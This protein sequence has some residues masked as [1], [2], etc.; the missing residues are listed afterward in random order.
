MARN[1]YSE[2]LAKKTKE[3]KSSKQKESQQKSTSVRNPYTDWL[4]RKQSE[5]KSQEI[6]VKEYDEPFTAQ[7]DAYLANRNAQQIK[8]NAAQAR[9]NQKIYDDGYSAP[10]ESFNRLKEDR[11]KRMSDRIGKKIEAKRES[12]SSKSGFTTSSGD[13]VPYN[14]RILNSQPDFEEMVKQ[15]KEKENLFSGDVTYGPLDYF[16]KDRREIMRA[17]NTNFTYMTEQEKELYYYLNGKYGASEAADYVESINKELNARSAGKVAEET[18]KL[19]QANPA[20]GLAADAAFHIVGSGAYPRM[21]AGQAYNALTGRYKEID[22][23]DPRY[24]GTTIMNE[25]LQEGINENETLKKIIPNEGARNFA[26]GTA[27]SIAENI[28]RLPFGSL[29]LGMAAASAGASGTRDVLQRGGTAGQA[30]SLGVLNAA[31]EAFFEKFSLENLQALKTSPGKGVKT[32]LRNLGK[33]AVVE[34]SEE[35]ATEIANTMTDQAIMG[36][37]STYQVAYQNYIQQGMTEE[38]AKKQAFIDFLGNVGL[39]GLGGAVSGGLMGGAG[40]AIG[41]IQE[42]YALDQYGS[43]IDQDYR[44]YASSLDPNRENYAAEA[45]YQE[46]MSLRSLAEE[47]ADRQGRGEFIRNRDK[48]EYDIRLNRLRESMAANAGEAQQVGQEAEEGP[49]WRPEEAQERPYEA[50]AQRNTLTQENA[51]ETAQDEPDAVRMWSREF[52]SNGQK[53]FESN[54][55]GETDLPTYYRAFG[56]VYNAGRYGFDLTADQRAEA[57]VVLSQEAF[58][59]ALKAGYQDL[60]ANRGYDVATGRPFGAVQGQPKNGGI[61]SVSVSATQAQRKVASHVGKLTGL[62]IDLVDSL[63]TEGATGSYQPGR[64]TIDINSQ[65]FNASMAHELTHFIKEQAPSGYEVFEKHVVK[66]MTNATGMDLESSLQHVINRYRD[67]GKNLNRAQAMEELVADSTQ[68]FMN[69]PEFI[70]QVIKDDRSLGQKIIDFFTDV[71]DALKELIQTGSTRASARALEEQVEIYERARDNWYAILE[72]AS[73]NYKSG[74]EV[75]G[76]EKNRIEHPDQVADERIEQNFETVRKMEPVVNLK[77][78]EFGKG[79]RSLKDRVIEFYE[80]I[81]KVHNETVGDIYLTKDSVKDDLAHGVGRVKAITFAAVPDILQKGK[82]LKYSK[83]WK[84]RGYDSVI[85]GAP[86]HIAEG[87]NAGDYYGLAVV[88]VMEDN[89]MYLHEVF[90]AKMGDVTPIKTPDFQGSNTRSDAYDLPSIYSIFGKLL[91]VNEG[92]ADNVKFQ[93]KE[94]V[95]ETKDLIAVH[96]L[97][98]DKLMKMLQYEGIPMPSI[99]VTKAD[100]GHEDFGDISLIFRKD[101]IDPKNRKNKVYGADAWT[102][103]FPTIEYELDDNRA[104]LISAKID[105]LVQGKVPSRYSQM[106]QSFVRNLKSNINSYGGEDGLIEQA[107]ENT[108][109]QAVYLASQGET[110]QEKTK[111]IRTE[112]LQEDR[113]LAQAIVNEFGDILTE[114]EGWS[115]RRIFDS[116]GGRIKKAWADQLVQKGETREAAEDFVNKKKGFVIASKF[117]AAQKYIKTGGVEVHTET[118]Y[119][120]MEKEIRSK[121]NGKDYR[122]W[123]KNLFSGIVRDSGVS[124]NKEPFYADGRRKNF[125]QT[126][127]PVTAAN[128]VK[129]MLSQSDDAR[130]VSSFHGIKSI[131]AVATE[132]FKSIDQIKK[133]SGRI[134]QLD[135]EQY[136]SLEDNLGTRLTQTIS[137]I[138]EASGNSSNRF[139]QMDSVGECIL[140]ACSNPTQANIKK[141]LEKYEWKVTEAQAG[142]LAQ[143]IKEVQE[144]P[145]DMFEAKPQRVVGYDEIAA[146]VVPDTAEDEVVAALEQKGIPVLLYGD[147]KEGDRKKKI[148]SLEGI[149]FQLEEVEDEG[150]LIRNLQKENKHL[151][152]A[153]ESLK[154]QFKL[155]KGDTLRQDDIKKVA[156]N[157]LKDYGSKY[158]RETLER[159]LTKLYDYIRSADNVDP[160]VVNEL[161]NGIAKS[162]LNNA[163]QIDQE[164]SEQYKDL[165]KQ[166]RNTKVKIEAQDKADLAAA[167]G[168]TEFRKKYFGKLR[169]GNDGISIDS[170]YQELNSQYP[171]LFPAEFTH[172]ADQLMAVANAVDQIQERVVNP[173][174]ANMDEM[175]V[176]LGSEIKEAYYTVRNTPPTFA[177]RKTAEL[178]GARMAYKRSMDKYKAFLRKQYESGAKNA[179]QAIIDEREKIKTARN[180]LLDRIE[181]GGMNPE[182][183]KD[184]K[185]EE[186]ELRERLTDLNRQLAQVKYIAQPDEYVENMRQIRERRQRS[187]DKETVLRDVKSMQT[188]L[189]QPNKQKHVPD[190]LKGIVLE[191]LRSID[192]STDYLN[193]NGEK[194]ARTEAWDDL[195][196]FWNA[197]KD[198]NEWNGQYYDGDPDIA[199]R[200]TDLKGKVK[201][202]EKLDDLS[203]ADMSSLRRVVSSMKKTIMEVN[204]LKANQKAQEVEA[205]GGAVI[206][207]LDDISQ[208]RWKTQEGKDEAI[209][210][211]SEFVGPLGTADKLLNYD[212][213]TPYTV[214]WKMG[215]NMLS[216]YQSFRKAADRKTTQLKEADDYVKKAVEDLGLTRKEINE[217]TG[218]NAKA[219]TFKTSGGEISLTPAMVMSLYVTNKRG[220]GRKH[221][222]GDG[223]KNAPILSKQQK[224]GKGGWLPSKVKRAYRPVR[225]TPGDV[226]AITNSLSQKQKDFA[227]RMQQFLMLNAADWGNEASLLMYGYKKFMS[228]DYWPILTDQNYIYS[229]EGDLSNLFLT[230][231]NFGMTKPVT[232]FANNAVIIDDIFDV[233]SRHVDQMSTYSAFL[234][235]LS[236]FNKVYNYKNSENLVSVKQEIERAMGTKGKDYLERLIRDIN[237][238]E[239]RDSTFLDSM[240]SNAKGAAVAGSLSVAIQQPSAYLRAAA[241]INP[242]YLAEG[243]FTAPTKQLWNRICKYAPIAQW[244]DWGFYQMNTSRPLKDIL[245]DTDSLKNRINNVAMMGA[246]KADQMTWSW[247]WKACENEIKDTHKELEPGTEAF[248]RQVGDRFSEIIDKTQ[249]VDSVLHRTQIMRSKD[250][251]VKAATAFMGEPLSTYNMLYRA[252]VD[253][254]RRNKGAKARAAGVAAAFVATNALGAALKSIISALRDDD[255]DKNY[256]QKYVAAFWGLDG[257]FADNINPFAMIPLGKDVVS[258]IKGYEPSRMEMQGFS[259]LW[260]MIQRV[261]KL[262]IGESK[263][264]A[265]K[266][267]ADVAGAVG[268]LFGLPVQ[269]VMK[270]A[271]ALITTAIQSTSNLKDDYTR[272]KSRYDIANEDNRSRY[273]QYIVQA[274]K[275]G[276]MELASQIY[277]DLEE[278]GQDP[279]KIDSS[280]NS[281]L[282]K[283]YKEDELVMAAAEAKADND[284]KGYGEA[285]ESL[286]EAGYNAKRLKSAINSLETEIYKERGEENPRDRKEEPAEEEEDDAEEQVSA[287][288]SKDLIW[289][290]EQANDNVPGAKE[291]YNAIVTE[292]YKTKIANGME[293]KK[294]IQSLRTTISNAFKPRW[295]AA[296]GKEKD[297]IL[298]MV[299]SL[300]V[301][302]RYIFS[303]YDFNNWKKKKE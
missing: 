180:A 262:K 57:A 150:Q 220:Q 74:Q 288:E 170:F 146:A 104:N 84:N 145:V 247:I 139:M 131:R 55:D 239:R 60:N 44:E 120:G 185:R 32:F 128:I 224:D 75:A 21:L 12:E 248:Y 214:F 190:E 175:A 80:Q 148:N 113:E 208:E 5:Q 142:E 250:F 28:A 161:A 300:K 49:E 209:K 149:K 227:D 191:F 66:A 302:D 261:N 202:I 76:E 115:G 229:A 47:Y 25:G 278:S 256:W 24:F 106:A 144:M 187:R 223:I 246:Q 1:P 68:R 210:G 67:A 86:I 193:R 242:K 231:R 169:L 272:A 147:G 225:V 34:G 27:T 154:K 36:E 89:R 137:D 238:G 38:Q 17:A 237:G 22:P 98:A 273:A 3:E 16:N 192:Y 77:G 182:E 30:L 42:N 88:K 240:L 126:H 15:G 116:Y 198:G 296:E 301:N 59:A 188:W 195:Q 79:E 111:E 158:K 295:Q 204:E 48:A 9:K 52:E 263:E 221:I 118:D 123:L 260:A 290:I 289:A 172:P 258:I 94:P 177:D 276:N 194:T 286:I 2:W 201:G 18:K 135:T 232:R 61:G 33:Q 277:S 287:Y 90:T 125:K 46:A 51:Q 243:V 63:E 253:V 107:M 122:S 179:K 230:V 174:H 292:I 78:D 141:T 197:V 73:E 103:T 269:N 26:T 234:A 109:M 23:N 255:E 257:N 83:N 69:D 203:P 117:K 199:N 259:D 196:N 133:A 241:E 166:L 14:T 110:I 6:G 4:S 43:T 299:K 217:W 71:I 138:V 284:L 264:T 171:E 160:D 72:E 50:Q 99:A 64:I 274:E 97:N 270:D 164:Q 62:T 219:T 95:E 181:E 114:T 271:D 13:Y 285:F 297:E 29:G 235:P 7:I 189:L 156:G 37:L 41:R 212:S 45:D 127:M 216:L 283:Q 265:A 236:D 53:A 108:G 183:K 279:E 215:N 176:L 31:A 266:V 152:E 81:G 124:N 186:K 102:A 91:N 281:I 100:M 93:L 143:I 35:I 129:S 54:Y 228:R 298:I 153:N 132:D 249:V 151:R 293:P 167:G 206:H 40:Q 70:E 213:L 251:G 267:V 244:K 39:A 280:I 58:D 85:I 96:N 82:V 87:N 282:T 19:G 8:N 157:L 268:N 92:Q 173:Y 178:E 245:F 140:E 222:H 112:L 119:E 254:Q 211:R 218:K 163:Q 207:D 11:Q 252:G 56:R 205:L 165:R 101:T 162:I 130:N 275:A 10:G 294:A 200:L 136:S 226:E 20:L 134:Q 105:Q 233:F 159:N 303:G 291:Q 184:A 121:T 168:Y 65:D 155:T